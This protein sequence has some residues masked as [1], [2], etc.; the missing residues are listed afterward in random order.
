MTERLNFVPWAMSSWARFLGPEPVEGMTFVAEQPGVIYRAFG[1]VDHL[2]IIIISPEAMTVLS[3]IEN[4]KQS[5]VELVYEAQ[6]DLKVP[7]NELSC[8]RRVEQIVTYITL[9][10]KLFPVHNGKVQIGEQEMFDNLFTQT[11]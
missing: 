5:A 8:N 10:S 11:L 1:G 9:A 2:G 7:E 6:W 4:N 3:L